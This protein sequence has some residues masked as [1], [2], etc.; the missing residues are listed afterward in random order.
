MPRVSGVATGDSLS[1]PFTNEQR[2]RFELAKNGLIAT[3][4]GRESTMY[5]YLRDLLSKYL[6][7]PAM[8]SS[9]T[10]PALAAVLT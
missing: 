10:Q 4:A 7:T 3:A 9:S 2:E 1:V 5:G 8:K 6:D